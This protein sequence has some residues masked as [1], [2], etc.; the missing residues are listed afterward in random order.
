MN[1]SIIKSKLVKPLLLSGLLF[2]LFSY[3]GIAGGDSYKIYINKKLIMTQHVTSLSSAIMNLQLENVKPGD[4]INI[5]YSHCGAVGKGRS[6]TVKNEKN[7]VV[8][9]WKF[10]DAKGSDVYMSIPVKDILDLKK[11]HPDVTLSM[12]Y[13]STKHLPRGLMLASI[14][15]DDKNITWSK[16]KGNDFAVFTTAFLGVV[17]M[18]YNIR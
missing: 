7:Q 16:P 12:Y 14:K 8:K 18:A 4:L 3:A 5:S 13:F 6:I 15:L 11:N 9:E 2:T 1:Q 10:A 17:T